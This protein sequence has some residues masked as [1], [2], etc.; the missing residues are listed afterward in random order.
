MRKC[1][2]QALGP[3]ER[4]NACALSP[5][6]VCSLCAI[7]IRRA[8]STGIKLSTN[9]SSSASS[10]RNNPEAYFHY[11][12]SAPNELPTANLTF[13]DDLEHNIEDRCAR[14]VQTR[15]WT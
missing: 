1:A 13:T 8:A 6:R 3:N 5:S 14:F 4:L 7:R 12:V 15:Y 9:K 11:I 10:A 2:C